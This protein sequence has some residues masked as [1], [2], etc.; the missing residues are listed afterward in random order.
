MS[1]S[2]ARQPAVLMNVMPPSTTS[3]PHEGSVF[4]VKR[5]EL[6]AMFAFVN[7]VQV[8]CVAIGPR[9][10]SQKLWIWFC[11]HTL[12]GGCGETN[13]GGVQ[14]FKLTGVGHIVCIESP[15]VPV[16]FFPLSMP[17]SVVVPSVIVLPSGNP[18]PSFPDGELEQ[19]PAR[20]KPPASVAID[21][22]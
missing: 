21:V 19:P 1:L 17:V 20:M 9:H 6:H 14:F 8:C 11:E 13:I 16:S 12:W 3:G 22:P 7:V 2:S 4:F 18:P 15:P 5:H 10:A